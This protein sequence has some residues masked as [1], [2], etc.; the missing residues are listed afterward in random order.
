MLLRVKLDIVGVQ[1]IPNRVADLALRE[2]S[3][4][5]KV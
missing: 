4:R 3:L 1:W 2:C 5:G